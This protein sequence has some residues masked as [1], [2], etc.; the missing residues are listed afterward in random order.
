L[1]ENLLKWLTDEKARDQFVIWAGI[2][3]EIYW[4][5][6]KRAMPQLVYQKQVFFFFD[7]FPQKFILRISPWQYGI[8]LLL[9]ELILA[10]TYLISTIISSLASTGRTVMFSGPLLEHTWQQYIT[11]EHRCGAAMI[12]FCV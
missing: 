9:V 8:P 10:H 5:D 7:L 11:R 12:S 1:Q 4:N 3:T 6:A 2:S